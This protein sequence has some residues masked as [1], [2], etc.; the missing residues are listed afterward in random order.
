MSISIQYRGS[1]SRPADL[2]A[3]TE[4]AEDIAKIMRW[5]CEIWDDDWKQPPNAHFE[6][7]RGAGIQIVGHTTLRGICLHPH[8]HSEPLWLV[9]RPDGALSSPF[10]LALDAGEG[11]PQ[12]KVWLSTETQWAG[13]ETHAALARLLRH[14]TKRYMP[15]LEVRDASGFWESDDENHLQLFFDALYALNDIER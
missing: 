1:I 13:P 9:F 2:E 7:V 8:P 6:S 11:Y 14:L 4:E 12:K 5:P 10:H 3:L 15:D